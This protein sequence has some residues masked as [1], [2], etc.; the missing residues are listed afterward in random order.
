MPEET[1]EIAFVLNK[2]NGD[3]Y[4]AI[5]VVADSIES[6]TTWSYPTDRNYD[7]RSM[8]GNQDIPELITTCDQALKQTCS[9]TASNC[10]VIVGVFGSRNDGLASEYNLIVHGGDNKL[11]SQV[12]RNT[13]LENVG[14]VDYYWFANAPAKSFDPNTNYWAHYLGINVEKEGQDV[15]VYVSFGDGRLPNKNDF[16]FASKM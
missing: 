9:A 16:D 15:D 1:E 12:P 8:E 14:D 13:T 3:S 4:M 11:I 2:T 7:S 10:I 5:K 6:Y